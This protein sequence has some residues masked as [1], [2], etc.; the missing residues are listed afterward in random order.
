MNFFIDPFASVWRFR[1]VLR[2]TT[3]GEVR[4]RYAGTVMGL[5]WLALAPMLLMVIYAGV[6][7]VIFRV[8]PPGLTET[9]YVLYVL[10]GL[11]PFIG[12]SE[13]LM[14]GS[15]SLSLN[16]A[17][18]LNTV[19]PAEL[20]PLRA[21]LTSQAPTG[22][23]IAIAVL[24]SILLDASSPV[25]VLVPLVWLLLT[26]FVAGIAWLLAL[27]SLLARDVQQI[28]TFISMALLIVSP[29]GYTPE[30]VPERL[31]PL[32]AINPLTPFIQLFHKLIVFG[33]LPRFGDWLVAAGLA[34]GSFSFGFWVFQRAKKVFFDYA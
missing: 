13:A 14:A 15:S 21:V 25:L 18:L 20:V 8:R 30:M 11:I 12:F 9:S 5:F 6:Y 7:L 1:D 33:E 19:F 31:A 22:V 34:L 17:I 26:L 32:M 16:K 4:F 2:R 29:I 27:V 24:L 23:G 3:Q 28:L 10:S